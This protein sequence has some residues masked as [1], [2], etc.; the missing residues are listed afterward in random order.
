MK[1]KKLLTSI[2]INVLCLSLI[3]PIPAYAKRKECPGSPYGSHLFLQV[4][5]V[6]YSK[7]CCKICQYCGKISQ[8]SRH[9]IKYSS[10]ANGEHIKMCTKCGAV[11]QTVS[12]TYKWTSYT[13]AT[14]QKEGSR[15]GTCT[16]CGWI[17]TETIPK[18]GH[19]YGSWISND[20]QHWVQCSVCG[21]QSSRA[22]H[23]WSSW[24]NASV[25]RNRR[26][27]EI[28]LSFCA[29]LGKRTFQCFYN[30]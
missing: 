7:Y 14:C 2:L 29:E 4:L 16:V 15:T 6:D 26:S 28:I 13:A 11:G 30:T 21:T 19:S 3:T 18:S 8:G 20:S 5:S 1:L 25:K 10:L 27:R 22:N 12:C 24:T 23:T 17:T 9:S